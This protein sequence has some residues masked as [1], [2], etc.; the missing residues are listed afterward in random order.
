M[1]YTLTRIDPNNPQ[2]RY[3]AP[4]EIVR[5]P[6]EEHVH[7]N[8]YMANSKTCCMVLLTGGVKTPYGRI[9]SVCHVVMLKWQRHSPHPMT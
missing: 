8:I 5:D 4:K 9:T 7:K 2:Q 6:L 1:D 3:P